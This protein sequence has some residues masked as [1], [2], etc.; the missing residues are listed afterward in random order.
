MQSFNMQIISFL[1]L[2]F[3]SVKAFSQNSGGFPGNSSLAVCDQAAETR[4]DFFINN[5]GW[6]PAIKICVHTLEYPDLG[7]VVIGYFACMAPQSEGYYTAPGKFYDCGLHDVA[8]SYSSKILNQ[9]SLVGNK[10]VQNQCGS[11]INPSKKAVSE[12]LPIDGTDFLLTNSSE[13]N[14]ARIAKKG[15]H[16]ELKLYTSNFVSRSIKIMNNAQTIT[17]GSVPFYSGVPFTLSWPWNETDE[18]VSTHPALKTAQ[19]TFLEKRNVSAEFDC[20]MMSSSYIQFT[21]EV[22]GY[23]NTSGYSSYPTGSSCGIIPEA[24]EIQ[25]TQRV[26]VYHPEVWGLHGWTVSEHHFFD[27][28]SNTL[29]NGT[30][31]KIQYNTHQTV[32]MSPYGQVD[33]VSRY[34]DNFLYIFDLTGEHLETRSKILGKTIYKFT[35]DSNHKL[36]LIT[37]KFNKQTQFI[38]HSSGVLHKIV[39]PYGQETIFTVSSGNIITAQDSLGHSYGMQYD[40]MNLLTQ[41]T[42]PNSEITTFTYNSDGDFLSESK[43]SGLTQSFAQ[44]ISDLIKGFTFSTTGGLKTTTVT[45]EN[46][47]TILT[48]VTDGNGALVSGTS[49]GPTEVKIGSAPT[50]SAYYNAYYQYKSDPIWGSSLNTAT[51][52]REFYYENSQSINYYPYDYKT[53]TYS[54]SS[55]AT[56]LTSVTR[57]VGGA[58]ITSTWTSVLNTS[59]KTIVIDNNSINVPTTILLSGDET[60][61]R[62]EPTVS[63]PIDFTYDTNGRITRTSK[64]GAYE[65]YEYDTWGYLKKITNSKSEVTQF[66]NDSQGKVLE[67]ILP[68]SEKIIFEYTNG[69]AVKTITTPSSQDHSFAHSAGDFLSGYINPSSGDTSYSYNSDK[70]ISQITLPSGQNINYS[71]DAGNGNLQ[72]VQTASGNYVYNS[73]DNI[74]RPTEMTSPDGI[75]TQML[76][77]GK[78]LKKVS[79]LD[80]DGSPIGDINITYDPSN[81]KPTQY[82][83]NSLVWF[84]I[85]YSSTTGKISGIF[86]KGSP[87]QYTYTYSNTADGNGIKD[88]KIS[89]SGTPAISYQDIDLDSGATP[90]KAYVGRR[91]GC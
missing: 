91:Q 76:W 74:G 26:S 44:T 2:L 80:D 33:L 84:S 65:D 64:S 10:T 77:V 49:Y 11:V 22:N 40:S 78:K 15:V 70:Q 38:Y 83:I 29:Y 12:S 71:Y 53:F 56:T 19:F 6:S 55:D 58:D 52:Y 25:Q 62:I 60:I 32:T 5:Y 13:F 73:I 45:S 47:G 4:R 61:S 42:K 50:A 35:Y 68:N 39:A 23:P 20:A 59:T 57:S 81:Y 7:E 79:W 43:N 82:F 16:A 14:S 75:K 3:T 46:A 30:G 69:G 8:T 18:L 31:E 63:Y 89:I 37:D 48:D 66:I 34:E 41:F 88:S 1:V 28:E 90:T 85:E 72:S 86:P 27:R 17:Y 24:T 87:N 67:K 54:N 21:R 36:T 51:P 9:N